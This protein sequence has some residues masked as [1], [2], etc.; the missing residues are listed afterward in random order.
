MCYMQI[1][2][3]GQQ[4][5]LLRA[6]HPPGGGGAVRRA[7]TGGAAPAPRSGY[8]PAPA[9]RAYPPIR[10]PGRNWRRQ[11]GHGLGRKCPARPGPRTRARARESWRRRAWA[12]CVCVCTRLCSGYICAAVYFPILSPSPP[13]LPSPP[14]P[15]SPLPLSPSTRGVGW[16]Q[17][18][19]IL[20]CFNVQLLF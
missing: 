10:M 17:W 12:V 20:G 9:G 18:L 8:G 11:L 15:L 4:G 2:N 7:R 5:M 14:L 13:P 3:S 6:P 16:L 19:V 1:C